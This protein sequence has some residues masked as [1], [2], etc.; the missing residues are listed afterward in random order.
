MDLL[1]EQFLPGSRLALDEH[2]RVGG[3]HVVQQPKQTSQLGI[4]ADQRAVALGFRRHELDGLL[5]GD[6]LEYG[7]ADGHL[8]A[9]AQRQLVATRPLHERAV[10]RSEVAQNDPLGPRLDAQV[11]A[12]DGRIGERH[13]ADVPRAERE[14]HRADGDR[15]P[16][17]GALDDQQA[18]APGLPDDGCARVEDACRRFLDHL[19]SGTSGATTGTTVLASAFFSASVT[20]SSAA[21]S[22]RVATSPSL[23]PPIAAPSSTMRTKR[24]GGPPPERITGA[25]LALKSIVAGGARLKPPVDSNPPLGSNSAGTERGVAGRGTAG[26]RTLGLNPPPAR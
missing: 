12:R 13:V 17:I 2:G 6:I 23:A 21:R 25:E 15:L 18:P 19:C 3:R 22:V 14:R 8:G 10:G 7:L 16:P 20:A 1:G 24:P 26:I 9:E 11:S 5:V 4:A